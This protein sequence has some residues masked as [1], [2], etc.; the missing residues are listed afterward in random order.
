MLQICLNSWLSYVKLEDFNLAIRRTVFLKWG[1][2]GGIYC[3]SL[4][5]NSLTGWLLTLRCTQLRCWWSINLPGFE[6]WVITWF[7]WWGWSAGWCA[8]VTIKGV[9][10]SWWCTQR[11]I[12][13]FPYSIT[14]WLSCG[15]M[16]T[17]LHVVGGFLSGFLSSGVRQIIYPQ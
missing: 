2:V 9:V 12:T 4:G 5:R 6:C 8:W 17:S 7:E 14:I 16:G 3:V 13:M 10:T 11:L 15:C 1:I